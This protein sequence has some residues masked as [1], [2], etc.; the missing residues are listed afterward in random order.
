M[1]E[2]QKLIEQFFLDLGG[3]K[4]EIHKG[5]FAKGYRNF[6]IEENGIILTCI[7]KNNKLYEIG[8]SAENIQSVGDIYQ[9]F[10][11]NKYIERYSKIIDI[12]KQIK[13][14]KK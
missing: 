11:D 12:M 10:I 3:Q 9:Y 8:T 13:I 7:L 2:K 14:N 4:Y 1:K 6:V 5:K